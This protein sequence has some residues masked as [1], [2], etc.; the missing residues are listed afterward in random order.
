MIT[1]IFIGIFYGITSK[2]LD[3]LP[4][5]NT[6]SGIGSA[7]TTANTYISAIHSFIPLITT[8][9]LA[10]IVFDVLF[11]SSYLLYKV[12]YWIIRRFPTQS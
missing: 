3:Y 8:T 5:V 10:I 11:E 6:N 12:I 9:I 4:A 1:S 7:I 2:I